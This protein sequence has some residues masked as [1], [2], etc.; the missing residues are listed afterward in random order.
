MSGNPVLVGAMYAGARPRPRCG[1]RNDMKITVVGGGSTYTPELADGIGRLGRPAPRDRAGA[2]WTPTVSGWRSSAA[3]ASRILTAHGSRARGRSPPPTS[4]TRR[5]APRPCSCRS[6]S[7]AR[8]ARDQDETWP[9]TCGCVG[10]ET[11]GAGGLAKAH[12]H[13]ARR[14]RRSLERVRAVAP[15]A[16]LVNFTNPVGIVTRALLDEGHRVDR[17]VQRGH[18]APA[19]C[20]PPA[21]GG[22]QPRVELTHVGLNHLSWELDVTLA[23]RRWGDAHLRARPRHRRVRAGCSS[24][25]SSCRRTW[26]ASSA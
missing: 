7:A 12:A 26:S 21:R 23:V 2:R 25:S 13:G 4:R 14:H 6:A 9:M 1:L 16:W 8:A 10:Q 15:D 5:R 18:R 20:S 24:R 22:R 19:R 3:S 11:T 17:A